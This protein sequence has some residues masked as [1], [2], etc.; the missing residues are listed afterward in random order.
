[1]GIFNKP[2]NSEELKN[3]P[4]VFHINPEEDL[5]KGR[6]GANLS[7]QISV[8][9]VVPLEEDDGV[10][11][12]EDDN[13]RYDDFF[14]DRTFTIRFDEYDEMQTTI[15]I[16][17]YSNAEIRRAWYKAD[18]YDKMIHSAQKTVRKVEDRSDGSGKSRTKKNAVI[19]YRG[20]EGWTT[21]GSAKSR[22][23]KAS[24]VKA[25]WDEQAQEWEV[26]TFEPDK[27]REVYLPFSVGS[28]KRAQQRG[29]SDAAV[30]EKAKKKQK[31]KEEESK[32]NQRSLL[33][34]SRAIL[35]KSMRFTSSNVVK[36]TK[37][38][39]GAASYTGKVA[40]EAGKRTVRASLGVATLDPKMCRE[41][42]AN[43]KK[44]GENTNHVFHRPS[45]MSQLQGL[46]GTFN[47]LAGITFVCSTVLVSCTM[48]LKILFVHI[49]LKSIDSMDSKDT[50][51]KGTL[52]VEE[53]KKKERLKLLGVV[54]LPGTK[55]MYRADIEKEKV[56]KRRNLSQLP[57]WESSRRLSG[58]I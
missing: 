9:S 11:M 54:P 7:K 14:P 38:V 26:G 25:V 6:R 51:P 32:K 33:L 42:F 48:V 1:M 56:G 44:A 34:R 39:G 17:D 49:E 19:N 12:E 18:D 50:I 13:Y 46:D 52:P 27:I 55:K 10:E 3:A 47:N 23:L 2:S 16:N 35:G 30:H 21:D 31:E 43:T 41:S 45:Q 22:L 36:T 40:R 8:R 28:L 53:T 37:I 5:V 24:A 29:K 57:S 58:K 15:H 20:L 4:P